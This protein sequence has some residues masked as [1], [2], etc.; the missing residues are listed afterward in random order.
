MHNQEGLFRRP[1]AL[2]SL[3]LAGVVLLGCLTRALP[4]EARAASSSEIRKQINAMKKEQGEIQQ[5]IKDVEAQYQENEDEIAD[6]IAQ[7]SVIDQ[8]ISLLSDEIRNIEEQI[9]S[10]NALIADKQEELDTAQERYEQLSQDNK[11][12]IQSMEEEG[13]I[14][15]WEV[16][17]QAKSFTDLLDRLNM[18]EEIAAADKRRIAELSQAAENVESAKEELETE[19]LELEATRQEMDE[20]EAQLD[21]KRAEADRLIQ[22]LLEKADDLD[23]LKAEFS[24]QEEEFMTQIAQMEKEFAKAKAAEWAAHMATAT[25]ATTAPPASGTNGTTGSTGS[26]G[27]S[28]G[29]SSGTSSGTTTNSS[30]W[31][32]PCSYTYVSSAFGSREAPTAGASTYHQGIDLA[33]PEGTPV[34]AARSGMVSASTYS[35]SAGNY[36]SINHMDGYSSIYMHLKSKVVSAGQTVSAG[37]LIGY[38]GKTGVATGFHLHFGISYNGVYVNPAAYIGF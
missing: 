18:V 33:A 6:I 26:S 23:A 30:S 5:K 27:S 8:Q 31:Q 34:Y 38:V 25:T 1:R 4:M 22:E 14:S 35:G 24:R 28:S 32:R 12:R 9:S 16:I 2:V 17:F 19:K 29:S 7:K 11:A 15:Y 20:T 3:A 36:V 13:S 37:Q 21:S 10:F